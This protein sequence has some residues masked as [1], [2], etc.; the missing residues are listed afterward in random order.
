MGTVTKKRLLGSK[1]DGDTITHVYRQS[2]L[3]KY[4]WSAE[5][6]KCGAGLF[7]AFEG[8]EDG[9]QYCWVG[10]L[11]HPDDGDAVDVAT[12][13]AKEELRILKADAMREFERYG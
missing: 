1:S 10:G 11:M 4:Y 9:V 12:D 13:Y 2:R 6:K 8:K 7:Y 3:D 5:S